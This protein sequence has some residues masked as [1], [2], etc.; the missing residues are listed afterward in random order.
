MPDCRSFAAAQD[1]IGVLRMTGGAQDDVS[2]LV[3]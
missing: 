3:W 1:D 2:E